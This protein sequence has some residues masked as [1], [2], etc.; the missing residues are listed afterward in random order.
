M[1]M[2]SLKMILQEFLYK[3]NCYP[4]SD[5]CIKTENIAEFLFW[6]AFMLFLIFHKDPY[7]KV[8]PKM[9]T[10]Y[11]VCSIFTILPMTAFVC[12]LHNFLFGVYDHNIE[13]IIGLIGVKLLWCWIRLFF[14]LD[15][16]RQKE[17]ILS[18]ISRGNRHSGRY[19]DITAS[20]LWHSL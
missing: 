1:I 9:I 4:Q 2:E 13:R 18:F 6:I 3:V 19:F 12:G 7:W 20:L 10:W 14:S 8:G 17:L 11:L 5:M 15:H 16:E